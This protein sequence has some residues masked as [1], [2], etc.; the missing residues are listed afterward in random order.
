MGIKFS[1]PHC[2]AALNVKSELAG[3][4]G[5][6]PQ[7]QEKIEIPTDSVPGGT[8]TV[9]M[10]TAAA[11]T[12]E[13]PAAPAGVPGNPAA[14]PQAAPFSPGHQAA[15]SQ[16]AAESYP[17]AQPAMAA[18][19]GVPGG[20]PLDPISE[21]PPIAVV[22]DA[23]GRDQ[24]VRTGGGRGIPR[25]DTRRSSGGRHLGLAARLAGMEA[26]R[27]RVSRTPANSRSS[28]R[29]NAAAR[30]RSADGSSPGACRLCHP[31]RRRRLADGDRGRAD[32]VSG[33]RERH[34]GA[35]RIPCRPLVANRQRPAR[36]LPQTLEH[37]A[38]DCHHHPGPGD[39]PAVLF[40]VA[41]HRTP[42][43]CPACPDR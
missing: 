22:R 33:G 38:H 37:G 5:R 42:N 26:R 21:A 39:D 8:G 6:C 3:K 15:G 32:A 36:P 16:P 27:A 20:A 11:Q 31:D 41:S 28:T 13:M 25:L 29:R 19:A 10:P 18:P 7:C 2:N 4:R 35:W 1:C 17:A 40:R 12:S 23:A 14:A 24:S 30:R 9:T 34:V 43:T